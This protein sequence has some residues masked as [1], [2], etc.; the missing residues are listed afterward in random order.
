MH[1]Y[2]ISSSA[3][4][5]SESI[6]RSAL[7]QS[8]SISRS[9]HVHDLLYK[10]FTFSSQF[11]WCQSRG[12]AG[13]SCTTPL[14]MVEFKCTHCKCAYKHLKSLQRHTREKH[15][16]VT[17]GPGV[18]GNGENTGSKQYSCH[19]CHA[20]FSQ[21]PN[22]DRHVQSVHT[23]VP[24]FVCTLCGKTCTRSLNVEMHMRTCTGVASTSTPSS[25]S[26]PAHRGGAAFTIR[27]KR[28]ALGGAVE[29]HVVDMNARNQLAMPYCRSSPQWMHTSVDIKP[30]STKWLCM[31][32]S[33]KQWIQQLLLYL[34]SHYGV[35]W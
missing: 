34:L 11:T 32:C 28:R 18:R 10:Q 33:I 25:S 20:S 27:R 5:Q 29:T 13:R 22:L 35:T 7:S 3:L 31:L 4:S 12:L 19:R 23:T 30:T 1:R 6:S 16:G 21:R 2:P 24:A 15:L 9:A 17:V 26:T 8:E 14:M